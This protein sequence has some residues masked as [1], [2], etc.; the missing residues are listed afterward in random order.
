MPL[1]ACLISP[2]GV[3]QASQMHSMLHTDSSIP[4]GRLHLFSTQLTSTF[5]RSQTV[6]LSRPCCLPQHHTQMEG[7][8]CWLS[9]RAHPDVDQC[10]PTCFPPNPHPL[11]VDYWRL[12]SPQCTLLA[13]LQRSHKIVV[14]VIFS[15][16]SASHSIKSD[17]SAPG[18]RLKGFRCPGGSIPVSIFSLHRVCLGILLSAYPDPGGF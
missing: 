7:N 11:Q 4:L 16:Q 17:L 3:W 1:N 8:S 9:F 14:Q 12:P 10:L 6:Y 13:L 18:K 2:L 5:I 15:N